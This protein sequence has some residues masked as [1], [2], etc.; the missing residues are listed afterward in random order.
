MTSF[1][2][3]CESTGPTSSRSGNKIGKLCD[4][5]FD[6]LLKLRGRDFVVGFEDDFAGFSVDDVGERIRAFELRCVDLDFADVGFA[7]TLRAT[8]A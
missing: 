2:K 6:D 3:V 7:Q 1:F 4:A 5:G 8:C